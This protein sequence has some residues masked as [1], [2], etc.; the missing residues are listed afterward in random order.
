MR[1]VA[2]AVALA[3]ATVLAMNQ[4]FAA[5]VGGDVLGK[6][7]TARPPVCLIHGNADDV[8]PYAALANASSV[9]KDHGVS[10]TAHTRPFLGH[11]IDMEGIAI[12]A[13]FLKEKLG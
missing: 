8:V 9:L 3:D 11:S 10:A 13:E 2:V 5:L 4:D 6:E 1:I 7:I 12:A